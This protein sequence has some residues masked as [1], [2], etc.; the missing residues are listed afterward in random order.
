VNVLV[1]ALRYITA[2]GYVP[3]IMLGISR[4]FSTVEKCNMFGK[5]PAII[6]IVCQS[7]TLVFLIV[8]L[9]AIFDKKRWIL[10]A[11]VPFGLVNVV[12]SSL[13]VVSADSMTLGELIDEFGQNPLSELNPNSSIGLSCF[14]AP[15]F[16]RGVS[17]SRFRLSYIAI[18]FFDTLMFIMAVIRIGRMYRLKQLYSS[19][20]SIASILLRDGG[21]LYA[22]LIMSNLF[23]FVMFM[24]FFDKA[25][26]VSVVF[27]ST[28]FFVVSSGTNSEITHALSAILVSRMIF[29]LRDVGTELYE[30]TEEW[31]SRIEREVAS[32][33]FQAPTTIHDGSTSSFLDGSSSDGGSGVGG[34]EDV[35]A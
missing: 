35:S 4:V 13:A 16:L 19:R 26:D 2:F 29:N 32:M 5:L 7:L 9:Y 3:I 31:R 11:T 21:I 24:R 20:S 34:S 17:L 22:V 8:R 27:H 10:Y 28:F 33:R 1:L 25:N 6:G 14:A 23:N 15:N 30:G 18:L 12:L